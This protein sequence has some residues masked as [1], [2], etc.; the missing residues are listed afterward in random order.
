MNYKKKNKN[1]EKDETLKDRMGF[2]KDIQALLDLM[3]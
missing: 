1:I 2:N 3:K